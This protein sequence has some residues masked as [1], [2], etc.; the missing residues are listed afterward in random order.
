MGWPKIEA[1]DHELNM[2]PSLLPRHCRQACLRVIF[3]LS[4]KW[5]RSITRGGSEKGRPRKARRMSS[6]G[7]RPI[8]LRMFL[9]NEAAEKRDL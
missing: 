8:L 1:A 3:S 5:I 2:Q 6:P 4:P 9:Q 7:V